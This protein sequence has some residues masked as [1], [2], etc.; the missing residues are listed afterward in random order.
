MDAGVVQ[1]DDG[2]SGKLAVRVVLAGDGWF[3]S[4]ELP[5]ASGATAQLR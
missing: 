3:V 4:V 2:G 5:V 1:N